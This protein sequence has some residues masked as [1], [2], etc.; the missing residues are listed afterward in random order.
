MNE[1]VV[2]L[3]PLCAPKNDDASV[4]LGISRS[5]NGIAA[6]TDVWK[7][8]EPSRHIPSFPIFD[9]EVLLPV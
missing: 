4:M 9:D 8:S 5:P 2:S 3:W 7:M 1:I 6:P